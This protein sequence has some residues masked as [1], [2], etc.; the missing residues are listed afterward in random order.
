[1]LSWLGRGPAQGRCRR[2]AWVEGEHV[3]DG[4]DGIEDDEDDEE[5][6]DDD[7]GSLYQD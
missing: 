4:A 7:Q 1:M 6:N 5:D 3:A 2:L